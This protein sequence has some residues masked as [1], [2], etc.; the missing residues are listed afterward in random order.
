[1]IMKGEGLRGL[2]PKQRG[3]F[4]PPA[5]WQGFDLHCPRDELGIEL[6]QIG[7]AEKPAY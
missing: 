5:G 6:A 4:F 3:D 7:E 1:M 2:L